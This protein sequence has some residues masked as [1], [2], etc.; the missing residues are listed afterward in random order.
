MNLSSY[1]ESRFVQSQITLNEAGRQ[2]SQ[3]PSGVGENQALRVIMWTH[4][5]CFTV[6][7]LFAVLFRFV[8]IQLHLAQPLKPARELATD[9]FERQAKVNAANRKLAEAVQADLANGKAEPK[10]TDESEIK[11]MH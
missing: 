10:P 1:L 6:F 9:H 2:Q 5:L 3:T 8:A 7:H 11:A 4:L